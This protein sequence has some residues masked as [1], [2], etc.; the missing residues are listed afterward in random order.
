[1][2]IYFRPLSQKVEVPA[3]V[4]LTLD[5]AT[6]ALSAAGFTVGRTDSENSPTVEEGRIIR[7][8]PAEGTL[9]SQGE[10]VNLVVSG[11][12]QKVAVPATQ[13]LSEADATAALTAEPFGFDVVV[14][15]QESTTVP[16]GQAIGT[17]PAAGELVDPGSE[18]KLIISTGKPL[19]TVPGVIGLTEAQAR[20]L[21]SQNGLDAVVNYVAVDAGSPQ[22]GIVIGQ[23]VDENQKVEAGTTITL[24]VGQGVATTPPPTTAPDTTVPPTDPTTTTST[25]TTSVPTT[26]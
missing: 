21:L 24:E 8:D 4:G 10:P 9:L 14:E 26:T 16:A 19:K 7:S 3:V 20:N 11:G 23:S 18:V 1:V 25:T 13:L 22:D 2:I 5:E 12:L 6:A 15:Q 17:T